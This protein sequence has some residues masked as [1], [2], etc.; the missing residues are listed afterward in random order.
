MSRR[1]AVL[2]A[3]GAGAMLV[4]VLPAVS[5][6]ASSEAVAAAPVVVVRVSA[7]KITFRGGNTIQA[8]PTVFKIVSADGRDHTLQIA[9]LHKGYSLQ[10][11]GQDAGKAFSGDTA[12]V[13][14]IDDG[15]TFRGG[16]EAHKKVGW[17][18][19]NLGAANYVAFDLNG[20]AVRNL[21]V[22]NPRH[23]GATPAASGAIAAFS[24][25]FGT[26]GRLRAH[27]WVR[28][29]NQSDQPHFFVFQRVKDG[30]TNRQVRRFFHSGAQGNPSW[31]LKANTSSAVISPF[32]SGRMHLDLP[33]GKYVVAC[34]W[35]DDDTGMP[36]AF[37]GMWKLIR[38]H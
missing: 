2:G 34:F 18:S 37:M 38:L 35:P 15:V 3:L 17:F 32:R 4:G 14:R 10:Q 11:F 25:G 7:D 22:V 5:A 6:V 29:Y 23:R 12:A 27:G 19:T 30:T 1:V 33:A 20:N 24:Y 9:R 21:K 26:G 8:G 28:V 16:A 31:G 13:R 36:H